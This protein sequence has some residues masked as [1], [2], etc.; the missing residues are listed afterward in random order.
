VR[1]LG[2]L[3]AVACLAGPAHASAAEVPERVDLLP[4]GDWETHISADECIISRSFGDSESPT[5]LELLSVDTWDGGFFV[6]LPESMFEGEPSSFQASW[7]PG[8]NLVTVNS[9]KRETSR[10]GR[11][12]VIFRPGFSNDVLAKMSPDEWVEYY[13]SGSGRRYW[14]SIEGLSIVEPSG[15]RTFIATGPI[16]GMFDA[17][18]DCTRD[19]LIAKGIDPADEQRSD[20][21]VIL[22]DAATLRNRLLADV[23]PIIRF[24][25]RRTHVGFMLYVDSEGRPTSCRLLSMPYD[26]DY[27]ERSC[28]LLMREARFRFKDG[29]A[30]QPTFYKI[31][32]YFVPKGLGD[33]EGSPTS[34]R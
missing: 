11:P 3:A 1:A 31:G 14:Q 15:R 21:R 13:R 28:D 32:G 25:D 12:T 8:G 30:A 5:L 9:P 4:L 33:R 6:A 23:P 18:D 27:E 10:G 16:A 26:A 7:L 2:W 17:F 29:E 20:H 24:R 19:L 22:R 34:D